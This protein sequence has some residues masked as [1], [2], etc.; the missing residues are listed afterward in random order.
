MHTHTH[1]RGPVTK[2]IGE[3]ESHIR[4]MYDDLVEEFQKKK[5]QTQVRG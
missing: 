4:A 5:E 1:T 2:H 3:L